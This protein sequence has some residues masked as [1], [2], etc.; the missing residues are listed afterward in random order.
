MGGNQR[1]NYIRGNSSK[2]I[3]FPQQ[4]HRFFFI[5]KRKKARFCFEKARDVFRIFRKSSDISST[6]LRILL[7]GPSSWRWWSNLIAGC[8]MFVFFWL[9]G[10]KRLFFS[11]RFSAFA[12]FWLFFFVPQ[13]AIAIGVLTSNRGWGRRTTLEDWTW[14]QGAI[15]GCHR[16]VPL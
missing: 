10:F 3:C 8:Q 5:S 1:R 2:K 4:I 7:W 13:I 12:T 11:Q 6:K 14:H 9:G 16:R 15:A